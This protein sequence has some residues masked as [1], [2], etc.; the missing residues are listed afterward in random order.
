M[1]STGKQLAVKEYTPELMT[2]A[3]DMVKIMADV[4][5]MA[6]SKKPLE[7]TKTEFKGLVEKFK[8]STKKIKELNP[9]NEFKEEH[10]KVVKAMDLYDEAYTLQ[11]E[12]LEDMNQDKMKHFLELI[13]EGGK[14][15]KKAA[16]NIGEKQ[17]KLLNGGSNENGLN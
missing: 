2:T 5:K 3:T 1:E 6:I 8:V 17:N 12:S 11:L 14:Y 15:W 10:Q 4:Q 16:A 13:A 9:P 7:E